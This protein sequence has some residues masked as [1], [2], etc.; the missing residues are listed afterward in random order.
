MSAQS[1]DYIRWSIVGGLCFLL[2]HLMLIFRFAP[3]GDEVWD[4]SGDCW[5]VYLAGGRYTV[6]LMRAIFSHC[7]VPVAYGLAAS[8]YFGLAVALQLRILRLDDVWNRMVYVVFSVGIVQ[9]SYL[10]IN[11]FIADAVCF[12][13]LAVT[14]AY[15]MAECALKERRLILLVFSVFM[16]MLGLGAY[17]LLAMLLPCLFLAQLLVNRS[18]PCVASLSG[19]LK[20]C[21]YFVLWCAVVVVCNQ[22]LA[23]GLKLLCSE[24]DMQIVGGYQASLITWGDMDIVTHVLHIGKQ[25]CMHLVGITYPGEWVYVTVVGALL[26]V[27]RDVWRGDGAIQLRVVYSLAAVGLYVLPFLP[28][29]A[30]GEDRGARLFLSQPLAYAALWSLALAP[31]MK[32]LPEWGIGAICLFVLLQAVYEV[33]SIAYYQQRMY[34]QSVAARA[35]IIR[36]ARHTPVPEGVDVRLCPI[37]VQGKLRLAIHEADKHNSCIPAPGDDFLELFLGESIL[38]NVNPANTS[39]L[40]EFADMPVYP[41]AGSI[42]YHDGAVLVKLR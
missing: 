31:R 17:Q 34:E 23:S 11:A 1:K 28:I 12:G 29:A 16:G 21:V 26:L 20:R 24:E 10:M 2:V 15:W 13:L 6:T 41:S 5:G 32:R 42:R 18:E 8:I 3:F 36:L 22:A 27:L 19:V 7:G 25:W 38:R 35:E 40:A 9:I 30:M 4:L 33:S 37:V 14:L 39:Q